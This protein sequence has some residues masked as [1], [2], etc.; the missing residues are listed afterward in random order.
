[1]AAGTQGLAQLSRGS[2]ALPGRSP[3]SLSAAALISLSL[4]PPPQA[5]DMGPGPR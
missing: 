1:M 3:A 4:F 5:S 2:R